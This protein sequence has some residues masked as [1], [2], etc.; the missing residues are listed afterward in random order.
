[1]SNHVMA[2]LVNETAPLC[3]WDPDNNCSLHWQPLQ[4]NDQYYA[5]FSC[6]PI[7]YILNLSKVGLQLN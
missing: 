3:L 2:I 6:I 7:S 4:M 5:A 1:M